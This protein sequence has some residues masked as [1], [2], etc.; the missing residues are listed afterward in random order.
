MK[1]K[2]SLI[3]A[4]SENQVIGRN[5]R[6]PWNMPADHEHFRKITKGKP[7]IMGRNSY[8]SEDVLLSD[9]KS[10]I[11]S[12]KKDFIPP[13]DCFL[14]ISIEN[15]FDLLRDEPEIFVLGGEQVFRQ[16]IKA[17]EYIYLTIIHAHINGD[18]YFP[19]ISNNEWEEVNRVFNHHNNDN[20]FN[21]TFVEYQRK[22]E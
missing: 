10:V 11:L 18:A 20:S 1:S 2:I 22:K 8:L 21:F 17:A 7:F 4:M 13:K 6:L 9:Y 14:A 19:V 5:N 3:A 16:I 15:A 12:H